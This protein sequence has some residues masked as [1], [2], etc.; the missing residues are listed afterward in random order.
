[1]E[2]PI[3]PLNTVLFPGQRLPLHIFEERYKLMISMCVEERLPFGVCLIREGHE[4]GGGARPFDTGTTAHI[5]EAQRLEDGRLNI[6]CVGGERFI[7]KAIVQETP[8][9][10]A[11]VQG[12]RQEHCEAKDTPEAA[13]ALFAEYVRLNL[14]MTNQWARTME[15]PADAGTLADFIGARLAVDVITKQ[16]LLE[17]LS[18]ELRLQG[19][20]ELLSRAVELLGSQVEL[21]RAARWH[22]FAVLN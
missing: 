20:I 7:I 10:T 3:F 8:Y 4:V 13:A 5:R 21:A 19:E 2:L 11:E 9:M 22:G 18:P 6:A 12:L 16:R 1:V 17:Q 15:M 14:A